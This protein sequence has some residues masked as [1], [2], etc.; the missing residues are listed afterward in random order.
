MDNK[1][2]IKPQ[3]ISQR[4]LGAYIATVCQP[5]ASF[6]LSRA[7]QTVSPGINEAALLNKR[8][9]WQKI[10]SRRG[11][12]FIKL[13]NKSLKIIVFTDGSFANNKENMTSQ[14]GYVICLADD[15][16]RANIVHWS[17]TKCKRITR[18]VLASELYAMVVGF[19][20]V[21]IIKSTLE[22]VINLLS[23][24][25]SS[26]SIPLILCTDSRSLYEC[27]SKLGTTT[28]KRLM[29]DIMAL[30]QSYDYNEVAEIRWI[31][32]SK[33]PA[34]AMTKHNPCDALRKLIDKNEV[35]MS[36]NS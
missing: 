8:L 23:I 1:S 20:M 27:L 21:T 31:E 33:N 29:I 25:K 28:E 6:D 11:L 19:D 36:A 5:E 17:S 14:I 30:R 3:Y 16:N 18:S 9:K 34:D 32:G 22:K 24:S 12:K 10:N 4:A 13:D 26:S 15:K 35:D 7:A 2:D